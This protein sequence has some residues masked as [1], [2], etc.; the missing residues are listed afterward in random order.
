MPK[1]REPGADTRLVVLVPLAL[2]RRFKTLCAS[3][4]VEMTQVINE[5]V[6]GYV[7]RK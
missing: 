3:Q 4:G 6:K 1:T 2:K 7:S 5:L